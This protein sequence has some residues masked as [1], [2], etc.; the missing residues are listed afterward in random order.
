MKN[1]V[2]RSIL[3][4]IIAIVL[5]SIVCISKAHAS[6]FQ[7]F[8]NQT[9]NGNSSGFIPTG[10]G[11]TG[12]VLNTIVSIY[13]TFNNASVQIEFQAVDSNWYSTDDAPFTSSGLYFAQINS[14]IP[15]RL[16]L[17]SAG[18]STNISSTVYNG[19]AQ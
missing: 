3:V 1:W 2:I 7:I 13:G 9:T 8:T 10:T 18:S 16:A 14:N 5:L 15:Y 19:I 11:N 4:S 12:S 17:S 6:N